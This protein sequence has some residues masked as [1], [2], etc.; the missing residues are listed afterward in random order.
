[1]VL[2]WHVLRCACWKVDIFVLYLLPDPLMQVGKSWHNQAIKCLTGS[3]LCAVL[4]SLARRQDFLVSKA[5][6]RWISAFYQ[7]EFQ[8]PSFLRWN[9][10]IST[11]SCQYYDSPLS[12]QHH[13]ISGRKLERSW[14]AKCLLK[15]QENTTVNSFFESTWHEQLEP[16]LQKAENFINSVAGFLKPIRLPK[17][18]SHQQHSSPS[19]PP[20]WNINCLHD[21]ENQDPMSTPECT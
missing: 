3:G 2:T 18:S 17:L 19:K 20:L 15:Q 4:S 13:R 1:M 6:S 11:Q 8:T 14:Y 7:Q 10:Q 5:N 12:T 21:M 16:K 9:H